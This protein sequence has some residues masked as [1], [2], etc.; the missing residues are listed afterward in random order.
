MAEIV[1]TERSMTDRDTTM[2]MRA[3]RGWADRSKLPVLGPDPS[4][5]LPS[6]AKHR[7]DS[8]LRLWTVEHRELPLISLV[9]LLPVGVAHDPVDRPGL[10]SFTADML[11][12][13]SGTSDGFAIH[14]RLS[15]MGGLFET[16][17]GSDATLLSL[18]TL[19][20]FARP[21]LELLSEIATQPRLEPEDV[22]RVRA[23][24]LS[25]LMQLRDVPS[26]L[27]DR[28][29]APRLYGAHPYG[30]TPMGTEASISA[31]SVDEL[32]AF[33]RDCYMRTSPV[34]VAVGDASHDEL[35]ALVAD[36]WRS[37][38]A[39]GTDSG[40]ESA[41]S[42]TNATGGGIGAGVASGN[43]GSGAVASGEGPA[44]IQPPPAGSAAALA[45]GSRIAIVDR[46]GAAQSEL[47]IGRVAAPRATTDFHTLGVLNVTLGGAFVSRINLNLREDKGYTYGARSSFEFRRQRGPF[48]VQASV[49]TDATA[50][51]VSEVLREITEIRGDR[52]IT[53][54]ELRRAQAA[55]VRGFPRGFETAEQVARALTQ[56]ALYG[57]SDDYFDRF[58]PT[59]KAVTA[60]KVTAAA[61]QYLPTD[62]MQVVVVGDRA[63]VGESLAK[64]GLGE[65]IEYPSTR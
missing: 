6:I 12:E 61:Q 10:A 48:A 51:S 55:L 8:G 60:A 19:S 44:A 39:W 37:M 32:R 13:G 9:L 34:L 29:F 26:A 52:P 4:L 43:A 46:P 21:A 30:H 33:H 27:A 65:P 1:G 15:R 59:V 63:R 58:I 57:L 24:R 23:L 31:I 2:E 36:T 42:S 5:T 20:R 11:D 38:E 35:V 50:E 54:D 41:G 28:I 7:F 64:L 45:G 14:E 3:A 25:R 16:E 40:G 53:E 47:R 56:L 17:V 49:Q 22:R 62:D 18:V